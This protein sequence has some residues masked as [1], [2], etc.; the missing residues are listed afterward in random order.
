M[1]AKRYSSGELSGKELAGVV[2]GAGVQSYETAT[3]ANMII[4]RSILE[5][6]G[7]TYLGQRAG[8]DCC[9]WAAGIISAGMLTPKL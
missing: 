3:A 8:C 1:Q 7:T 9:T 5:L 4:G 2:G 6:S